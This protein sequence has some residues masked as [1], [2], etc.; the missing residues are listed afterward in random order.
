MYIIDNKKITY[1][2][3]YRVA[4]DYEKVRL[5]SRAYKSI[6]DTRKIISQVLK[7]RKPIY[8]VNTGFG[9][10][11]NIAIENDQIDLL[12]E[13][14]ILSHAVGT[15]RPFNE[16]IVRGM[17]FLIANYLSKGYSGVR[18][19]V[20]QTLIDMLNKKVHPVVPEQGSVGS[21]GDLVPSAHLILVLI[22][23]GEAVYQGK[24]LSGAET[25]EQAQIPTI[26]LQAKEGLA[27]INNTAA[28]TANAVLAVT[29]AEMLTN[30]ADITGALSAEALRVTTSAFDDDLHQVKPHEG[31]ITVAENLRNF[32]HG[33][34]MIDNTRLQDQ[35]SIRCMPQIH[36]AI[37][38]ALKY[39]Q[40][41]INTEVNSVTDNPLIFIT[42][43]NKFKVISGGNFHGESVAIAMDTLGIAISELA[44]VSDRRVASLLDPATNN[45]LPAFLTEDG[46]INSGF[47]IM[48]YTTASLV[49]EDK[50]LAH[51][52]SVDS[53]P[54][55]ANVE[56]HVSMGTIAARKA[57]KIIENVRNVLIIE[58]ITASQAI[59]FRLKEHRKLGVGTKKIYRQIRKTVPYFP[60]D[61]SY[62]PFIKLLS[63]KFVTGK[64]L[65]N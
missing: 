17:M 34:T 31:Q 2:E 10:F 26:K 62:Y 6:A 57:V 23:R 63:E 50:V 42:G 29:E 11:K 7:M 14:L 39:V 49:S 32:L 46:G 18:P 43:K 28:M 4:V 8:G 33:S 41:I 30:L 64:Y 54:T 38:E 21:S 56:D 22:G 47:M 24:V 15:G 19:I 52:A 37:R 35:Y 5:S 1:K 55:S 13:N 25:M 40:K 9:A 3:V 12:Q 36:G 44:N 60:K 27:L 65:M 20:V 16:K 53:I 58:L 45:G 61:T 51:P 48:Q 59:D